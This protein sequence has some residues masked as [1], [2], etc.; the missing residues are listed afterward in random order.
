MCL[1]LGNPPPD[2]PTTIPMTPGVSERQKIESMTNQPKCQGCHAYINPF[3]FMQ[4]NY[5]AIGRFRTMDQGVAIDPKV[6][7]DFLDEGK[8]ETASPVDAFR[9]LTR[10]LRFQQCFARQLFRFYMGR[11]ETAGD[12]PLLRQMF[13]DFA[14]GGRQDIVG[15]LRTLAGSAGFARRSEAP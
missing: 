5:D 6:A 1:P 11:Q 14:D 9:G 8:L 2:A 3:G 10:S 4:E 13:F 12:D 7:M 15:M